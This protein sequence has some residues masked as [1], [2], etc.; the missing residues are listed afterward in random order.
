MSNVWYFS[1]FCIKV[2]I[3]VMIILILIVAAILHACNR[4]KEMQVLCSFL[5][6]VLC[7]SRNPFC[8]IWKKM[9]PKC[10]VLL[11]R[12]QRNGTKILNMLS[13]LGYFS[14]MKYFGSILLSLTVI[15]LLLTWNHMFCNYDLRGSSTWTLMLKKF[16]LL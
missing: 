8:Q 4:Q 1:N 14:A 7:S 6:T 5:A 3:K 2:F 15:T 10:K 11:Q 13:K 9:A 12:Y 16:Q